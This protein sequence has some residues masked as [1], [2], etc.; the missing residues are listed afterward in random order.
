MSTYRQTDVNNRP[1]QLADLGFY[2][3]IR[4]D[5]DDATPDYIGCHVTCGASTA[6]NDWKVYKFYYASAASS[7]W[8]EVR[9][10]Y[11]SWAGRASLT[12]F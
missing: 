4:F 12:G 2:A 11:G 8:A 9:F 6:L 3:D 7:S 1:P 5:P 10:A